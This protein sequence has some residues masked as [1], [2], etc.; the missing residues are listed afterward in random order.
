[1]SRA[2][3]AL[4]SAPRPLRH[5]PGKVAIRHVAEAARAIGLDVVGLEVSADGL[6]RVIDRAALPRTPVDD[7]EKWDE[8]GKL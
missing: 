1:M 8:A 2:M 5:Y 4:R 3:A 6:I 7:F